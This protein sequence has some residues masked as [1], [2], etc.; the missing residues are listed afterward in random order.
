MLSDLKKLS[1]IPIKFDISFFILLVFLPISQAL[2]GGTIL[3]LSTLAALPL[4]FI[5]VLLH[6]YGHCWAAHRCG[7]SVESIKLWALGGL[8]SLDS[9]L[10]YAT[11]REEIFIAFAGP[12]VNFAI[13]LFGCLIAFSVGGNDVI[14][15]VVAANI[16][17]GIF[18]LIPAFPM[19]GGRIFRGC[20]YY[21][22]KDKD[23]A[24][25]ISAQVGIFFSVGFFIFGLATSSFML[26]MIF[27]WVG[28]ICYSILRSENT[29][30]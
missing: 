29:I 23:K 30:V 19:D 14:H 22:L 4:L 17:L 15:Y 21:F 9:R 6:E 8:A 18:N 3:G 2:W 16:V 11:S 26:M 7:Y 20:L 24:T 13:A 1:K 5:F 12:T 10:I 27:G 28:M 25:K